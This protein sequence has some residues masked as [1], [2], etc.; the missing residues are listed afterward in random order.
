M[1]G[2]RLKVC[3]GEV[4]CVCLL[5]TV[6]LLIGEFIKFTESDSYILWD[7]FF[8][9]TSRGQLILLSFSLFGTL[10]WLQSSVRHGGF[11]I[12]R[13][14]CLLV[15]LGGSVIAIA[16]YSH[17]P[18]LSNVKNPTVYIVGITLYALFSAVYFVLLVVR[19]QDPPSARRTI[20]NEVDNLIGKLGRLGDGN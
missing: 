5:S 10:A 1:T 14:M 8:Q 18:D 4:F 17:D 6:P 3:F 12:I 9:S 19:E 7:I 13:V 20:D 15:W 16:L 2:A 11:L